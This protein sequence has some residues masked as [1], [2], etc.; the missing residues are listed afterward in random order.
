[1]NQDHII[2]KVFVEITVN[3]KEKALDIKED[4]NSFLSIDVF[5]EI[6]K[7]IN[8]LEYELAGQTLQIPKLALNLDIK[9]SALDS[10]LKDKIVQLFREELSEI[11]LPAQ[12]LK[13]ETEDG[14]KAYLLDQQEKTV[15][16]FL[17]F[18]EKGYMPW[19]N[20]ERKGTSFL[21]PAVF[22][23]MILAKN[24]EKRILPLLSKQN[25]QD[26]MINQLSNEQMARLC[27][28]ILRNKELKI[29]LETGV[30]HHLSTLSHS[31]R[32]IIWKLIFN[33]LSEYLKSSGINNLQE[34][35]V[36]Q[37][38]KVETAGFTKT[39]SSRQKWETVVKLFPSMKENEI[40]EC[41]K[42]NTTEHSENTKSVMETIEI[43]QRNESVREDPDENNGQYIQNAGLILI[44]PFIKTFFEHCNLL[45]PKTQQLLDPELCAHL[46]HYI[47]TGNTN[48]PEYDMVFEKFL[49]NIPANKS[50]SRHIKLSRQHKEQAEN[51]IESV[52][53]NWAPM[54]K[55]S[56]ALLQN[57]F[58]QRSG[59]LVITDYDYTLTVERKTQDILLDKLAW[60]IGLVKL[61]WQEKFI[62]INW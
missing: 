54:R 56:A 36:Q 6:E 16:A 53:H 27:L 5:P 39:K 30:I 49:C 26:R 4:I 43:E 18:L 52:Q 8:T 44:H 32:I 29:N 9:S 33:V 62:F 58:F 55:S 13:Q 7:Y 22:D 47:A 15:Q 35:L 41:I 40:A 28:A 2:Q 17:F 31:D 61:P 12:G 23:T 21:E 37:L 25:V 50:I 20:P 3:N 51:V 46:L 19:W 59:K 42:N 1:M 24:F 60:G 45:D 10:E 34:Y 57:E 38:S 48:A 11:S 14:S